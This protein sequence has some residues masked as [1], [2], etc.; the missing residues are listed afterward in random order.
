MTLDHRVT[1]VIVQKN[2]PISY[3]ITR[4]IPNSK[5]YQI[6]DTFNLTDTLLTDKEPRREK[7]P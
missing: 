7:L 2:I 5:S 4:Y 6:V 1:I 3:Q